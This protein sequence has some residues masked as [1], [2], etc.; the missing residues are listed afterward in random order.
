MTQWTDNHLSQKQQKDCLENSNM[1]FLKIPGISREMIMMQLSSESTSLSS[2]SK[3]DM[4]R[5]ELTSRFEFQEDPDFILT[6]KKMDDREISSIWDLC[7]QDNPFPTGISPDEVLT[8]K[9]NYIMPN[10][11]PYIAT[12]D[13]NNSSDA[14]YENKPKLAIEIGFRWEF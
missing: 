6:G 14:K 13:L 10:P 4:N 9:Q 7:D 3:N 12:R 1:K 5:E 8:Q 11:C 2:S